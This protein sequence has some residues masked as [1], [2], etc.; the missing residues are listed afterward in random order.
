MFCRIESSYVKLEMTI[1]LFTESK[2]LYRPAASLPSLLKQLAYRRHSCFWSV[3]SVVP[4]THSC[5]PP[6]SCVM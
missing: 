1:K 5:A 6:C 4:H 3:I 2:A